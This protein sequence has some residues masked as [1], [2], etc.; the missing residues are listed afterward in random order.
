MSLTNLLRRA[1]GLLVNNSP[2]ILTAVGVTGAIATAYLAST[3]TLKAHKLIEEEERSN[4]VS[5]EPAEKVRLVWQVYLPAA[6]SATVTVAA[7]IGA[8]RIG[9]RRGAALAVA[10]TLSEKAF[11]EYRDKMVEKL[12]PK[13]EELAR[14]EIAQARVD[15][16]PV[17]NNQVI[18]ANGEVLCYDTFTGRYFRSDLETIR[19]AQNDINAEVINSSYASLSD[20]YDFVGLPRTSVSDDIGWNA[21]ELLDIKF[22]AVLIDNKPAMSIAFNA[23]PTRHYHRLS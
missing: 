20:F 22:S 4:E 21:D 6:A 10:Y 2:A 19:K 13:K 15:K 23:V 12:G 1:E 8:N 18:I 17:N 14:A 5:L 9:N 3:A 16:N 7:I 11:L